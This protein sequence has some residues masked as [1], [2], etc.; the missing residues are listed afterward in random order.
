MAKIRGPLHSLSA[1]GSIGGALSFRATGTGSVCAK[2]PQPYAQRAQ[3]QL[4]N[5]ARMSAARTAYGTLT[6][7]DRE[8]W[9]AYATARGGSA[10]S[11]F[12][13]EYQYQ[14]CSDDTMP[15]IPEPYL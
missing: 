15:L 4:L 3:E 11:C 12:F 13:A 2:K 14:F 10:W 7:T 6:T 9:Q 8:H 5:Q 1:S